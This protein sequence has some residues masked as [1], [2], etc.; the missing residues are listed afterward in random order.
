[1]EGSRGV[2]AAGLEHRDGGAVPPQP[3]FACF[4]VLDETG[5]IVAADDNWVAARDGE[6]LA[7][8]LGS[9]GMRYHEACET[10]ARERPGLSEHLLRLASSVREVLAGDGNVEF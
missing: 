2:S 1:M 6:R 8:A 7:G 4:A 3:P 5:V 9:V 10:R